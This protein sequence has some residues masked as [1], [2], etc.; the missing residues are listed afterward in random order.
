[1]QVLDMGCGV[2]DWDVGC[3]VAAVG[4][5]ERGGGR[6]VQDGAVG[7]AGLGPPSLCRDRVPLPSPLCLGSLRC[8]HTPQRPPLGP[9]RP[10]SGTIRN[11][12]R[13]PAAGW[14]L[15]RPGG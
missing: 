15:N 10:G 7:G 13:Q 6:E 2:R 4:H 12:P 3:R 14:G 1:M 9:G 11:L 8:P 5:K